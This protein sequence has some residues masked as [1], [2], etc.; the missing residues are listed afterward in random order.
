MTRSF[1]AISWADPAEL[2]LSLT[3]AVHCL[4]APLLVTKLPLAEVSFFADARPE[5]VFMFAALTLAGGSLTWG[6]IVT[7]S[8]VS[9]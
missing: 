1:A 3:C 8:S 6:A 5:L 9:F 2:C 7:V 4:A